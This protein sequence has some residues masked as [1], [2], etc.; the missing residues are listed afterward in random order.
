MKVWVVY[1]RGE[2]E[3]AT[4]SFEDAAD[5]AQFLAAHYDDAEVRIMKEDA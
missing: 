3:Y 2:Q 5:R 4:Q 1:F